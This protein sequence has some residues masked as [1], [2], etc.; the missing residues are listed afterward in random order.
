M[1][2]EWPGIT[3]GQIEELKYLNIRTLEQLINVTDS[4]AQGIM[5]I[6]VLKRRAA[7]F[8]EASKASAAADKLLA[9]EHQMTAMQDQIARLTEALEKAGTIEKEAPKKRGRPKKTEEVEEAA[10]EA[11]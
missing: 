5:G 7:A 4:N 8:M 11:E 6:N 2:E 9:A 10:E 1:L 3:R